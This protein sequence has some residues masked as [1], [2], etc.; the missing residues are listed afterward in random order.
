MA[1]RTEPQEVHLFYLDP[2]DAKNAASYIIL[3][4]RVFEGLLAVT[5]GDI[6]RDAAVDHWDL[7]SLQM[8]FPN[9]D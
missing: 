2:V 7:H 3:L 8:L 1:G 5:G 6:N 4:D 9:R